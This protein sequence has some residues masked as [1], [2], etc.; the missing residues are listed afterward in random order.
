MKLDELAPKPVF[1]KLIWLS[2]LALSIWLLFRYGLPL[3]LAWLTAILLEPIV[4]F[5]QRTA[6]VNRPLAVTIT[7]LLL[8][9]VTVFIGYW[10]GTKLIVQGVELA[11]R[12]PGYFSELF[13]LSLQYFWVL[14]SYY[15]TLPR[16][17]VSTIQQM[18]H[19]LKDSAVSTAS[20]LGKAMLAIVASVPGLLILFLVYLVALLLI[21]LD[22]PGLTARWM[23]LFSQPAR[24]KL[25]VVFGQLNR[26]IIGFIRAQIFLSALTFLITL[27]GL[28][29]LQV[30][31]AVVLSFIIM[32]V[33]VLP[34]L[35]T[36]SVLVPWAIYGFIF[37]DDHKLAIGLLI[38]YG[39]ISVI[40]RVLEPKVLGSSLG[41]SA[42][43]ALTSMF[44]GFQLIGFF[45]L[46]L[47]PAVVIIYE[48]LRKAGFLNVKID[49]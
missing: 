7:F 15:E 24:H 43:S 41:I 12:L 16:E 21:S 31:Y 17:T 25:A 5:C 40:R 2:L 47:G 48:A 9:A 14:E 33:D 10:L 28:L 6:R 22:L 38:L 20:A 36:G 49:F 8:T 18:I 35:G 29:V 39:V 30:K 45:G 46:I 32:V 27:I 3:V 23:N 26:A 1:Y 37:S 34:I 4:L 11:H 19:S 42:L 13:D 44:I